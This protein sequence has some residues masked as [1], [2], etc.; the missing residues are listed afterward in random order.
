MAT[1][2]LLL[3]VDY[4]PEYQ[5]GWGSRASYTQL[6]LD[7]LGEEDTRE[8]LAT[9]L[10][11]GA[12][13]EREALERLILEKTEGNPF[14]LEEVVQTLAEEGVLAGERGR[15]RL[16]RSPDELHLPATVQGVL[17]ARID[18]LPAQEKDLLQT[19]AVIGKAFPLGL[20]RSVTG[21]GEEDLYRGLSQ[22]QAGEFIYEQPAFPEPEYRFKHALT[23]DV[24]YESQLAGSRRQ[25]HGAVA[26]A[27][28]ELHADRLDERAGLLAYHWE[29]AGEAL[30]AARYHRR[31]AKWA[32]AN[33]PLE[34]MRHWR[35]VHT[36]ART[37]P[38]ASEALDL[39]L[40][41]CSEVLQ[42]G[43]RTGLS[44]AEIGSIFEDGKRFAERRGD[45]RSLPL[46]V[47]GYSVVQGFSGDLQAWRSY[48]HEAA[49]LAE[50]VSDPGL[51]MYT[52]EEVALTE[53]LLGDLRQALSI[54]ERNLEFAAERPDLVH[55][56]LGSAARGFHSW[57]RAELLMHLGQL[58]R[59]LDYLARLEQD[60]RT[61][62][63]HEILIRAVT[64]RAN[65]AVAL[66][67][68]TRALAEAQKARELAEQFGAPL[69]LAWT[70]HA[71]GTA[72]IQGQSWD[73]AVEVLG[74]SLAV[75]RGSR[76]Y[77]MNEAAVLADLAEAHLGRGDER[78]AQE[79]SEQ[80]IRL[81]TR[82]GSK[83]WECRAQLVRARV[84]LKRPNAHA[85]ARSRTAL[86][87]ALELAEQTGAKLYEP[88]VHEVWA[89]LALASGEGQA[90]ERHLRAAER[91]F[92]GIGA[93]TRAEHVARALR[94]R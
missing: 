62:R 8:L 23:R 17:A 45:S 76:I 7:P 52:Q 41:A 53:M 3:L 77:A 38:E 43:W 12:S 80:S 85:A 2:R 82:Q 79:R 89:E 36:L 5:H 78:H 29:A 50:E 60:A 13:A 37:N 94:E 71:V 64:S 86:Q 25:V 47:H 72:H 24:A 55:P 1:A 84:L 58:E 16:E 49:D 42:L 35:R 33:D 18:R 75:A 61:Q 31:A 40:E 27:L 32:L 30:S 91:L 51:R 88:Q 73:D 81:A 6:R 10:G 93:T 15:Y 65:V 87:R 70:N 22:L 44:T 48:A 90:W 28:E 63:N 74:R 20:V 39:A 11:E 57:L 46:L 26:Q 14:F 21:R 92:T 59:S 66:G 68:A 9:L 34:A 69:Y 67:Q 56:P 54:V 4:R 19:L 83:L